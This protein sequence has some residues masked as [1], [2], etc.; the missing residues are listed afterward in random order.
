MKF[1]LS[2]PWPVQVKEAIALQGQLRDR[3]ISRDL[4]GPVH[5]VAGIDV[6][7]EDQGAVAQAA[8]VVLSFPDLELLE[9]AVANERVR[10]SLRARTAFLPRGV[11]GA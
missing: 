11:R 4:L 7:F 10:F 9:S 8:V 3:V 1:Q 5:R 6:G 2:H